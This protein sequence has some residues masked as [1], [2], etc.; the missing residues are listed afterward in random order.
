MTHVQIDV[1][2]VLII[3]LK[4]SSVQEVQEVSPSLLCPSRG[5]GFIKP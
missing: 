1:T 2:M 3:G 4:F 5:L